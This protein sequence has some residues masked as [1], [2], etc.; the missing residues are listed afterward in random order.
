MSRLS[1]VAPFLVAAFISGCATSGPERTVFFG[2][3]K[4]YRF[5]NVLMSELQ[6]DPF[7]PG[8]V[9]LTIKD[10]ADAAAL[11]QLVKWNVQITEKAILKGDAE[12]AAIAWSSAKMFARAKLEQ[13]AGALGFINSLVENKDGT[14]TLP[15]R[16]RVFLPERLYAEAPKSDLPANDRLPKGQGSK[17]KKSQKNALIDDSEWSAI[18]NAAAALD[19]S[20]ATKVAELRTNPPSGVLADSL[21]GLAAAAKRLDPSQPVDRR[22]LEVMQQGAAYSVRAND[23]SQYVVERLADGIVIHNPSAKPTRID[24]KE[25]DY[26][27]MPEMPELW[28]Y[29]M[30]KYVGKFEQAWER[31]LAEDVK[32]HGSITGIRHMMGI[33]NRILLGNRTLWVDQYGDVIDHDTP[34]SRRAFKELKGFREAVL[35]STQEHMDRDP[36]MQDTIRKCE[37]MTYRVP[38][39]PALEYATYQ[40]RSRQNVVTYS[41][42][43]YVAN[44]M[45]VQGWD[46]LLKD[47]EHV[48]KL[49]AAHNNASLAEAAAAF[50]PAIG[51]VDSGSRCLGQGSIVYEAALMYGLSQ[52]NPDVRRFVDFKPEVDTPS[53]FGKVLDCMMPQSRRALAGS[54]FAKRML[55]AEG[56]TAIFG[57]ATYKKA[58]SAFMSLDALKYRGISPRELTHAVEDFASPDASRLLRQTMEGMSSMKNITDLAASV[59]KSI[60]L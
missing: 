57:S 42:T 9:A 15:P 38:H 39:G 59:F 21:S 30:A 35:L 6:P 14:G 27:P 11:D 45:Q 2:T 56:G 43:Y 7:G 3:G 49:K 40:C 5:N 34:E 10:K 44:G 26:M 22:G 33:P 48:N 24:L 47:K 4:S 29:E 17:K 50:L 18:F 31:D 23:G 25:I 8:I 52:I 53:T 12:L 37:F 36:L 16:S 28:R 51:V 32:K 13:N 60:D 55:S 19:F 41:R 20:G 1:C 54:E 58:N 46:S